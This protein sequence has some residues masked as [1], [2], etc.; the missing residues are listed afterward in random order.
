MLK[1]RTPMLLLL[2]I[3]LTSC[4]VTNRFENPPKNGNTPIIEMAE[5]WQDRI[6]VKI[7]NTIYLQSEALDYQPQ[8]N[9]NH[10]GEVE[11]EVSDTKQFDLSKSIIMGH[12]LPITTNIYQEEIEGVLQQDYII[13]LYMPV[14]SQYPVFLKLIKVDKLY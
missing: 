14:L 9:L 4:T 3:L 6:G 5:M 8:G 12:D 13:V 10:L 2:V 7:E 1:F 11:V